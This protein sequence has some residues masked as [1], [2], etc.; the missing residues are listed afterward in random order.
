MKSFDV[1]RDFVNR[2]GQGGRGHR[3]GFV[4]FLLILQATRPLTGG[5]VDSSQIGHHIIQF[6]T[7]EFGRIKLNT[8]FCL[9]HTILLIEHIYQLFIIREST[10]KVIKSLIILN[11][12]RNIPGFVICPTVIGLVFNVSLESCRGHRVGFVWF[13]LILQA[14]RPLTGGRC[15]SCSTVLGFLLGGIRCDRFQNLQ[16][17]ITIGGTIQQSS[18]N[19]ESHNKM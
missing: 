5:R 12:E 6:D 13:L 18:S 9:S 15:A 4:W 7:I 2:L 17:F 8:V 19:F 1:R 3:V 11:P 14:T 16:E 10:G